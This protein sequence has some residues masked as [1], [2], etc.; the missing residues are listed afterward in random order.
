[1]SVSTEKQTFITIRPVIHPKSASNLIVDSVL[2]NAKAYL[3]KEIMD[4]NVAIENGEIFK[5]GKEAHMPKADETINLRNLLVLPGLI[6]AHVH[7]RDE[8]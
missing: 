1:M 2:T 8:E 4:C 7:L 3:N 5:I 6:D